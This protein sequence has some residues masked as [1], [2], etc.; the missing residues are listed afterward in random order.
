MLLEYAQT[1]RFLLRHGLIDAL[2]VCPLVFCVVFIVLGQLWSLFTFLHF[3]G[4][5]CSYM[6]YL[7]RVAPRPCF[8]ALQFDTGVTALLDQHRHPTRACVCDFSSGAAVLTLQVVSSKLCCFC[9]FFPSF[10]LL[11][12]SKIKQP[13]L[14]HFI[15]FNTQTRGFCK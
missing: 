6:A 7:R 5:S 12:L 4:L 14:S 13:E 10:T 15:T 3:F 9:S 1:C 2:S 11:P 8:L